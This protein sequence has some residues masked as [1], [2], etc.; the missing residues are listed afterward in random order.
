MNADDERTRWRDAVPKY[1]TTAASG[2]Q[3]RCVSTGPM[4][5]VSRGPATCPQH[6]PLSTASRRARPAQ[7]RLEFDDA[8]SVAVRGKGLIGRNPTPGADIEHLITLE[9]P[10]SSLSRT[11]L[12]F[13]IGPSGLWIRDPGSTNG[14][15]IE[16][17]GRRIQIERG[18]AIA[19]PSGCT[20]HMGAR[21]ARV[22]TTS[23][24]AVIADAT[25]D[26]G[27]ASHVG[28]THEEN[29]DAYGAEA[30]VFVVADGIGG[31]SSGALASREAVEALL[32]L[33]GRPQVDSEML[34]ACLGEARSRISR[35][36]ADAGRDPGTTLSGVIVTHVDGTGL[37]WMVLN[38]GDSRTYRLD[39]SGFEQITVDHSVVQ[40]LIDAG[41]VG[42]TAARSLPFRNLLTRAVAAG[43]DQPADIWLL[44]MRPGDRMLVCSDG[45]PKEVKDEAIAATLQSTSDPLAAA[46]SLV[47]AAVKSEGHDDVTALVVDA[48][49]IPPA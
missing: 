21:Q 48:V 37:C 17:R 19:A 26:W 32:T 6:L 18:L 28:A 20:I 3:L 5:R 22:R 4:R 12:E 34:N 30:P 11:H 39:A 7:F 10:S 14:T 2:Q 31:H 42:E 24:R 9:D 13:G 15:Q 44:P 16:Y 27:V 23:G 25:V 33:A 8:T 47:K 49:T 38:I 1:A 36:P 46:E 43:A 29:E 35:I 40:N 41:T 45:L